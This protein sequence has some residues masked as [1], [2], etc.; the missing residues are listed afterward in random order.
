MR[1]LRRRQLLSGALASFALAAV[2]VST[3]AR[4]D[5]FGG[6]LGLLAAIL[7]QTISMVG[8]MATM[9]TQITYQVNM[10][11]MM[12]K[13][14][15]HASFASIVSFINTARYSFNSLTWGIRSMSYRLSQ[16]DGEFKKLFPGDPPLPGTTTVA[17]RRQTAAA[18]HQ[19]VTAAAQVA[20]RQQTSIENLEQNATQTQNLL[21]QSEAAGG[22]VASQLQLIAQL[23][24]ITNSELL[25]LNQTFATTGRVLTDMA[26]AESSERQMSLGKKDDARAGYT[27]KGMPVPVPH[28]LP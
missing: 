15:N 3:P 16:I 14:L 2:T 19:E 27:D 12:T 10:L 1:T 18:W 23:I 24:G 17:E 9:I 25:V 4:A 28:T 5:L 7:G 6:D 8:Q 13:N 26:A 21:N 20:S 11:E 22:Q